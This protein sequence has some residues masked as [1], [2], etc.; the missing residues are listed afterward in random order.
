MIIVTGA[1]GQLGSRVVHHLLDLVPAERIGVSTRDTGAAAPL[2]D[3]GV[4]VRR[5]DYTDPASLRHAFQGATRVLVI[6]STSG[7]AE[8]VEQHVAAAE[9]ARE[10][11]AERIVYTSH[12][13]AAPDSLFAPMPDHAE[14]EKRLASLGV[15]VTALRN[16]FY[17]STVPMLLGNALQTGELVAPADGPVSWTTHDD[18]A[19]AAAVVL[20]SAAPV[21]GASAALTAAAAHDLDD[22]AAILSELT[23]RTIRRVV[24][25]DDAWV[26][27][28]V[29]HGMPEG[30]A[31]FLLG[32][33]LASRR[34]EFAVTDPSL[35]RLLGRPT[36]SVRTTLETTLPS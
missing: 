18:L 16:G 32:M 15:P 23:G 13:A 31:R 4:R 2:L 21:D 36:A 24:A 33:F 25:D 12:Q 8:A 7:G 1:T 35:A 20:S 17:A 29:G 6:S 26:D 30:Q 28:L 19:E 34:G 9:A 27:D 10:A 22:V 11:G 14:T 5:G 3:L